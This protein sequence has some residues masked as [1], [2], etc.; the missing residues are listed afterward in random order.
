[1]YLKIVAGIEPTLPSINQLNKIDKAHPL[2]ICLII[3]DKASWDSGLRS[4]IIIITII[5]IIY[6]PVSTRYKT[7]HITI[8]WVDLSKYLSDSQLRTD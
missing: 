6:F 1:M 7:S 2:P 4:V 5:I 8:E 3:F